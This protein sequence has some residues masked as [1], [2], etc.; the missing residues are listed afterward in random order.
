MSR[1][2]EPDAACA[3]IGGRAHC[4]AALAGLAHRATRNTQHVIALL[5]TGLLI[6]LACNPDLLPL[7]P[8]VDAL[9]L[10]VVA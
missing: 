4:S 7:L 2:D 1:D 3:A 9:E 8:V 5:C 6:V 10:D